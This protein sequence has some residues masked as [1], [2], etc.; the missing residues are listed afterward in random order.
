VITESDIKSRLGAGN[1]SY[2]VL[3][4][5]M[6]S[7]EISK[8]TELKMYRT[9]LRPTVM[10]DCE[11]WTMSEHMQEALRVWERQILRKVYDP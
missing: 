10:Y 11:G 8:S 7:R 5:I 3:T 2:Y 9:I 4:T 6:K 1:R